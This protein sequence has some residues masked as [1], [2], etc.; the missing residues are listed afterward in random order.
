ML[1]SIWVLDESPTATGAVAATI[2]LVATV[3]L[4]VLPIGRR[5]VHEWAPVATA[6][7][8]RRVRRLTRFRSRA[9]STGA[10][11]GILDG[12]PRAV[13]APAGEAPPSLRDVKLIE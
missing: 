6:Y 3:A 9:P 11:A 2:L 5:T 12:R 13:R 4:A 10:V 8:A 1:L 7:A